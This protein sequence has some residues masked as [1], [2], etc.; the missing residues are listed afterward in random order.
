MKKRNIIIA[1]VLLIVGVAVLTELAE[2]KHTSY[3]KAKAQEKT[4][5]AS[6]YISQEESDYVYTYFSKFIETNSEIMGYYS[7][8]NAC[9]IAFSKY[10]CG[11]CALSHISKTNYLNSYSVDVVQSEFLSYIWIKRL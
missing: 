1:V 8:S 4:F 6:L 9:W 7:N 11:R 3:N 2:N 10:L 5:D